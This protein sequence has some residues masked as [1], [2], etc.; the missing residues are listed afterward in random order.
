MY[1]ISKE[2]NDVKHVELKRMDSH[3]ASEYLAKRKAN[4][5]FDVLFLFNLVNFRNDYT[6]LD[7]YHSKMKEKTSSKMR[8]AS[9]FYTQN[10]NFI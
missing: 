5:T 6:L 3:D 7:Y 10:F 8:F 1:L 9:A 4:S 2:S